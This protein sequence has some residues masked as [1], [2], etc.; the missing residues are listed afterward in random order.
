MSEKGAYSAD[1]VYSQTDVYEILLFAYRHGVIVVPEFDT[2][3]R[4]LI[5]FFLRFPASQSY[6]H[7]FLLAI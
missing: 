2:P 6:S 1:H 4:Y 3:G 5:L 7:M